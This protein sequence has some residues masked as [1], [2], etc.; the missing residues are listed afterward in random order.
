MQAILS[1]IHGN[2]EALLAVLADIEHRHVDE[3]CFLGDLV[4]YGPNPVECIELSWN[5]S[6]CLQGYFDQCLV[7]REFTQR[8]VNPF[9][10][11]IIDKC[12]TRVLNSRHGPRCLEYLAQLPLDHCMA[13]SRYVH[14]SPRNHREFLFPEDVHNSLKM[15][16]IANA[17]DRL[18]ICGHTHMAGVFI[19]AGEAWQFQEPIYDSARYEESIIELGSAKAICNVG[20]VGQPRDGDSR[21]CYALYDGETIRFRRVEYDIEA[22]ARKIRD[23]PDLDDISP[24]DRLRG[25]W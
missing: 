14:G 13:D 6:W 25:G 20:S 2:L 12:R 23:D 11:R 19:Q 7:D 22:T 10:Q 16:A 21:A 24:G 3:I 15:S 18:C 8:N 9:L 4:V 1:D 17:F 5:W